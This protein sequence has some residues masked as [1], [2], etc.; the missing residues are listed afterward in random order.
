MPLKLISPAFRHLEAIPRRYTAE[1]ASVSPPLKW[2]GAHAGT[3]ELALICED[4]D[5]PFPKPFV[6]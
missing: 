3:R 2:S 4:P 5:A 6:H 1:E